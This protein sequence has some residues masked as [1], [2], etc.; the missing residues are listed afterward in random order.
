MSE[1][2]DSSSSM[3]AKGKGKEADSSSGH[4]G[5]GTL[6]ATGLQT[7]VVLVGTYGLG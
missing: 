4:E 7:G 5:Q 1:P 3:P 6:E 2:P